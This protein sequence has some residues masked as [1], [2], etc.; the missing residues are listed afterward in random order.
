MWL[1]DRLD[2]KRPEPRSTLRRVALAGGLSAIPVI[3]I[4]LLL[5]AI[6]PGDL[7]AL[8]R[9]APASYGAGL[10]MAFVV[11][12]APEEAAKMVSMLLF[13]WRRPEFDERMDGIT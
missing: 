6:G 5:K 2:A 12:A 9:G 1:F 8:E 4:E 11:A 3:I 7:E 10:Y 13:A